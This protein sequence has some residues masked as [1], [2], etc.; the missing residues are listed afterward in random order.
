MFLL[1]LLGTVVV[2]LVWVQGVSANQYAEQ[3]RAQRLRDVQIAPMRGTIYDREGEPLAS[4]IEARTVYAN[5]RQ[6]RDKAGTARV[7][8]EVLGGK[9]AQ[10]ARDLAQD[11]GFVYIGRK[12]DLNKAKTLERMKL[13]GIGFLDDSRRMYPSGSL[14]CQ[15]L[16]FVGVDDH[17]LAGLEQRYDSVLAGKPGVLLAERDPFGREIPGGV[18]KSVDPV[19]GS[20]IVLTIDKD[21][22]GCAQA[23]LA[24]AVKMWGARR[25]SVVV[26]NP[27]TGEVYAIASTPFFDPNDFSRANPDSFRNRAIQDAY[28]PGSTL[29]ALLAAA[30]IDE[31]RFTPTSKLQL[32]SALHIGGETIRESHPRGAVKWSLTEVVT[33][34]SNVGAAKIG[35]ALGPNRLRSRL[36]R[37]GFGES[38]GVD[39]GGEATGW[40]PGASALTPLTVG[41]ISFGQGISVTPLQLSRAVSALANKGVMPTPHFLLSEPQGGLK[42]WRSER[43]VTTRTAEAST[44]MLRTVVTKGTGTKAKVPGYAVAGKTG[45]AQVALPDGRGYAK[46]VYESSFVGYLPAENPEVVICVILSAPRKAIYGGAVAAPTF[47]SIGKFCMEHLKVSPSRQSRPHKKA[48]AKGASPSARGTGTLKPQP[49]TKTRTGR[50]SGS[51]R[52]V[53]ETAEAA[54][55]H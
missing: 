11:A 49:R 19:Q 47:A 53:T 41:T 50:K 7:L 34:S 28:E 46:G 43:V 54:E 55:K 29:K 32:P 42:R 3:A 37:F 36:G 14:A 25:G 8:A 39:F 38:T 4:S 16:G 40:L 22:Q 10:Y 52:A 24:R 1:L 2:R 18:V 13:E 44:R 51:N 30:A 20:D 17:G 48:L 15:V 27:K 5:P 31:K 6:V 33:N 12:I 35:L 9:P 23:E 21:I 45:T 26:M